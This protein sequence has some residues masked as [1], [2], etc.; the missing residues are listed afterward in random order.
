MVNWKYIRGDYYSIKAAVA[1]GWRLKA[2]KM[3]IRRVPTINQRTLGTRKSQVP[4]SGCFA[5][6][7]SHPLKHGE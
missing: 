7:F 2:H 5:N 1:G 6:Y 3:Y 4:K